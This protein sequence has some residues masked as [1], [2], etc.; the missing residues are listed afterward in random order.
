MPH[1]RIQRKLVRRRSTIKQPSFTSTTTTTTNTNTVP[2]PVSHALSAVQPARVFNHHRPSLREPDRRL[3]RL[4][5]FALRDHQHPAVFTQS[6][7]SN[8]DV[9]IQRVPSVRRRGCPQPTH[10]RAIVPR[11]FHRFVHPRAR[12]AF[13]RVA[14]IITVDRRSSVRAASSSRARDVVLARVVVVR[15]W[16]D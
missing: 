7:R 4:K 3:E 15:H 2:I 6:H 9:S 12:T 13:A 1:L 16:M 8:H 5:R 10:I 11:S 14:R